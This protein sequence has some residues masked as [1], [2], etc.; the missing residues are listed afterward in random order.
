MNPS[1]QNQD[2]V[3]PGSASRSATDPLAHAISRAQENLLRLQ[4]PD[5]YW[6]GELFVDSTLCSDYVLFMHWADEVDAVL[7]E[8]C[9]ALMIGSELC[10]V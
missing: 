4:H 1:R 8:K 10:L 6:V 2:V 9:V 5:G 3:F 7:Q